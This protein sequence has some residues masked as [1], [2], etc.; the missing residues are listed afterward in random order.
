MRKIQKKFPREKVYNFL[1]WRQTNRQ[2]TRENVYKLKHKLRD[3]NNIAGDKN[4]D[5]AAGERIICINYALLTYV[6]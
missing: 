2:G 6:V 3:C 1:A 5:H 4:S